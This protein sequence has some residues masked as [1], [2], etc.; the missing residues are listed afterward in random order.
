MTEQRTP[1][2]ARRYA[3]RTAKWSGRTVGAVLLLILLAV[4]LVQAPPVKSWVV[5]KVLSAV[6][7]YED[8]QLTVDAVH[9]SIVRTLGVTDLRLTRPDGSVRVS[10]DS[11][12]V[13]FGLLPALLGKIRLYDLDIAGLSAT[14]ATDTTGAIDLLAPFAGGDTTSA[15]VRLDRLRLSRTSIVVD[16]SVGTW[17]ADN[18]YLDLQALGTRPELRLRIDS[19]SARLRDPVSGVPG[20][21]WVEAAIEGSRV[22]LDTLFLG[23]SRSLVR[24]SGRIGG[25]SWAPD[26]SAFT[27]FATPLHTDDIRPL[28]PALAGGELIE[29]VARLNSRGRSHNLVLDGSLAGG[30][31]QADVTASLPEP[32]PAALTGSAAITNLELERLLPA[33][34]DAAPLELRAEADLAGENWSSLTGSASL[35]AP[36][37][38]WGTAV[39]QDLDVDQVWRNG[40]VRLDLTGTINGGYTEV[41]GT[42][43]PF[44]EGLPAQLRA[45]LS[46]WDP[47]AF[48][49]DGLSGLVNA[50]A[51]LNGRLTGDSWTL[52]ATL[53]DTQLGPCAVSGDVD[54][55]ALANRLNARIELSACEGGL[56]GS[57]R[58]NTAS[59]S[60]TLE[61]LSMTD[62]PLMRVLGDTTESVVNG[63]VTARGQAARYAAQAALGDTRYD[64]YRLDSLVADVSGE[65]ARW[66]AVGSLWS[67]GGSARFDL[68]GTGAE[69]TIRQTSFSNLDASY[70]ADLEALRT[71]ATGSVSGRFGPVETDLAVAL[72]SSRVN[73]Q[74]ITSADADLRLRG[75]SLATT[76]EIG[77]GDGGI[78]WRGSG[79]PGTGT[80]ALDSLQFAGINLQRLIPEA[81]ITSLSGS[82]RGTLRD[83]AI[84]AELLLGEGSVNGVRIGDGRATVRHGPD[85]S[86][87]DLRLGVGTG[88]IT[89]A[90]TLDGADDQFTGRLDVADVD[91][92][93]LAGLDS[94]T[95]SLSTSMTL[96]GT[97]LTSPSRSVNGQITS[98]EW[99][100]DDVRIDSA[101]GQ[102]RWQD[103]VLAVE[104][105]RLRGTPFRATIE[106]RLPVGA[107]AADER[108]TLQATARGGDVSPITALFGQQIATVGVD[109][110]VRGS[111]RPGQF[112]VSAEGTA[113]GLRVGELNLS[114]TR[115]V[116]SAELGAELKPQAANV[117]VTANQL[118]LPSISAETASLDLTLADD[119]LSLAA[120]LGLDASQ[121]LTVQA[122]A[123]TSFDRFHIETLQADLPGASWSL[124]APADVVL[125]DGVELSGLVVEADSQRIAVGGYAG[126]ESGDEMYFTASNVRLDAIAELFGYA[127]FGGDLDA[128]LSLTSQ[129]DGSPR[130]VSGTISGGLRHRST[131]VG[132][133]DARIALRDRMLNIDGRLV[134]VTGSDAV[135]RGFVPF[136][137][138]DID[139][140]AQPVSLR[141]QAEDLPIGWLQPFIDPTLVDDLGGRLTGNVLIR[142]T[143]G[144]PRL[145]GG[146]ALEDGRVGMPALGTQRSGLVYDR[147]NVYLSFQ[148][149][150]VQ[151]DS[152][153][154]RSGSG[155]ATASGTVALQDLSLGD[156]N[157][158]IEAAEFLAIES[159]EYRAI[160]GA[161]LSL[162]G[163]TQT[164]VLG[165]QVRVVQ[166]EFRLTDETSAD[167]FEPVTLTTEDLLTLEQRFGIRLSASDTTQFD[168][169]EAMR[170]QDLRVDLTRNTWLRSSANP[171]M[172]IQFTGSLD[173]SKAPF[174]DPRV[175][176]TIEVLPERSRIEQ[177][178]RRFEIENGTL[179]FNGPADEPDMNLAAVYNVRSRGSNSNEVTI[180]LQASGSPQDLTVSFQS[181]P[182]MELSDIVSYIATGRPAS[183][184][185]QFGGTSSENYLRSAAG[186]AVG[187]ITGLVENLAGSNLGLDVVEIEQD[188][189][190]GLMLTA[191]K[192]VSPRFFVSVSQPISL[193]SGTGSSSDAT[194]VTLEYELVRS[195]LISLLSRGTV[196]RVNLRWER[197]F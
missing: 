56:T 8:A 154:V 132:S 83:S 116:G 43:E 44:A 81:P 133:I 157:L 87:V 186:L 3:R 159:P 124:A 158:A 80:V 2:R 193:T 168:F 36:S 179:T 25:D 62:L 28:Y 143:F 78:S 172:D 76:G 1:G 65:G 183:E 196:L 85:S 145:A 123:N 100:Y 169:Y 171:A 86:R 96:A 110:S 107:D 177:F 52:D 184:S 15:D 128:T 89:A 74:W 95:S 71:N 162:R 195:I 19:L 35:E 30:S 7:P 190:A 61:R 94:L 163:N 75:D 16:D 66:Q 146:A 185:L 45:T 134:H 135:V 142:G 113:R 125:E 10:A 79:A 189:S 72:D 139:L 39:L 67:G 4:G 92:L 104:N 176:G 38:R 161:D 197:A 58:Y 13:T 31:I 73:D 97:R 149:D 41:S 51:S 174:S 122:G 164:P 18:L 53:A 118:S 188:E 136:S 173:V 115:L 9:G 60:W 192:Y 106:G 88:S 114:R 11:V 63:T 191:G 130:S 23:T 137:L 127:G 194:E 46:G 180:R 14:A 182:P 98:L 121:R 153:S 59:G 93:R 5:K 152:A 160:V 42:M 112:Q 181:D 101:R 54:A 47:A 91:A 170:I 21:L 117:S 108:Y 34:N 26:S 17:A 24:A 109:L 150:A 33:V 70:A 141:I 48:T 166:G 68:A 57:G 90:G 120:G 82:A 102:L 140:S 131:D 138:S 156:F 37:F 55:G 126:T 77:L 187:P 147:A 84:Q 64:S 129:G 178:G 148:D 103:G 151:V 144:Q 32:G 49:D 155:F 50:R 6:N 119:S 40:V 12:R 29:L 20:E 167:A 99:E 111:G 27:L 165:G 22:R 175:F 69:G 105:L